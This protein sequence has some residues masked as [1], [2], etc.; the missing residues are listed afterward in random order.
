MNILKLKDLKKGLR[1][2]SE[3]EEMI[4]DTNI[5]WGNNQITKAKIYQLNDLL[6]FVKS[7]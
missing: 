2:W 3:R 1:L 6:V 7:F 5:D 4:F